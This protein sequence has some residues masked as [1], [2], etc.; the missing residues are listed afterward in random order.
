MK[1]ARIKQLV[2]R[3]AAYALVLGLAATMATACLGQG[4]APSSGPAG[5]GLNPVLPTPS[6]QLPGPGPL[7]PAPM[8]QPSSPAMPLV[9]PGFW[10]PTPATGPEQ[11]PVTAGQGPNSHANGNDTWLPDDMVGFGGMGGMGGGGG[12]GG[13]MNPS[14]S[15][16]YSVLWFP[17][18]PVQG[19]STDFETVG[20]NL[21]FTHPL[22]KDP[23]N[24][25]SL[26]GG[27]RNQLIETDAVLPDTGQPIPSE[28][29]GVN[30]GLRYSRQLDDGWV[31]GGGVSI[32][33]ASDHPF[34]TIHEMNVGMNA[35]LR[36]PQGEHNAW[37]F[38]LSYAPMGELNFPVPGVAFSWNP[39]PEF[40]ANIGL[41]MMVLWRPSDDWQFQA[42]YMLIR[43]IHLK[44]QYRIS[45]RLRAFAAY[46]W[47]NES[48]SLLDRPELDDRFFIYDQRAS[49]G[50]QTALA[51]H[52]TASVSGGFVFDRY[53]FEGTSSSSNNSSRVDLGNGP[54]AGLNLQT[55][56]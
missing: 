55:R 13:G 21:S 51:P 16:R 29:W 5:E 20:E 25:L 27:V 12:F 8:N 31:T 3:P 42:S 34:A 47:S 19:Q 24:A 39:S 9:E 32:G 10:P 33:S 45:D 44:A 11:P 7:I 22:W 54:F 40:H 38:T 56:F 52:W 43:T 23:L 4:F 28:L 17:K 15:I 46:D 53:M 36:I 41:P 37:L 6:N 14:D 1:L 2:R 48:Y 18:V 49:M 50:L 35:M 30:F 26:T